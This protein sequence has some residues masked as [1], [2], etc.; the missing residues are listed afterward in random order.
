VRVTDA[1]TGEVVT[2]V[3]LDQ[4]TAVA[5]AALA[6]HGVRPGDR[7]LLS[8]APTP[9]TVVAYVAIQRL[10]AVVVPANTAYTAPELEH[11]VNDA[12]PAFAVVDDVTRV[13]AHNLPAAQAHELTGP[14]PGADL[15]LDAAG[16]RDPA[17]IAYTS[18]TTGA[19]KGAV[20]TRGNLDAGARSVV[21]AW[22]WTSDDVL[23]LPLPLFHMHGLGVGIN[24]TRVAGSTVV[25]LPR[26]DVDAVL[27]AVAAFDA[28]M[29]FGVP[30]MWS[31]LADSARAAELGRLRLAVSGSAPMSAELWQQ[32]RSRTGLEV[33]E[34][35]GMSETVMLTSNPYAGPRRPGTVGAPL[36]GVEVRLADDGGVEVRGPNV[37]GGYWRRPDASR[38]AFTADGWFKTGDI[39]AWDADGCLRLVG[40]SSELIITAGY[41]VYPR[42]VED[43]LLTHPAVADCAVV[44]TPDPDRGEVVTAYVVPAGTMAGTVTGALLTAHLEPLLAPYKRPRHWRFV[45]ALPRNAMGK[46]VRSELPAL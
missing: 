12:G 8:C 34:R 14:R 6:A 39:G 30:T 26:F 16:P 44:G 20:L 11:I 43:A 17:M 36:A 23:V 27:D 3:D 29:L 37:F 46:V 2:P 31:R 41:N 38:A 5:A 9:A 13:A 4:R 22:A 1:T 45:E 40:R 25:L 24:G 32:V 21:Q 7:V 18:G 42:E 33:L 10:G 28:T 15:A 35:Y 19:P